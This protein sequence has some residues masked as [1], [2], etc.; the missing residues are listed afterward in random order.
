[1]STVVSNEAELPLKIAKQH[2]ILTENP[3]SF[4]GISFRKILRQGDGMPVAA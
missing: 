4:H 3:H 1:M 2:E